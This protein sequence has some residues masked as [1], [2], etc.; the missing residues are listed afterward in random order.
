MIRHRNEVLGGY[1]ALR[2]L[3]AAT[4]DRTDAVTNVDR[5]DGRTQRDHDARDFESRDVGR[6]SRWGGVEALT[7]QEVSSIQPGASDGNEHIIGATDGLVS[8]GY[9]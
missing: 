9:D 2:R 3:S 4:E 8:F 6:R 5:V 7:L 1:D